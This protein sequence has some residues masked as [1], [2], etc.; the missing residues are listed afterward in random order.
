MERELSIQE[1]SEAT[2]LSSHTLRYYERAG[3]LAPITRTEGGQRRFHNRD[4]EA[5]QF[6]VKLRRTGM[7]I[8]Q[9][10]RYAEL[11]REGPSTV[12]ERKSLLEEHRQTVLEDIRHLEENL[13]VL[14]HKIG[15]YEE[16]QRLPEDLGTQGLNSDAAALV[17][18]APG[19]RTEE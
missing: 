18:A 17:A 13:K 5:L 7:P 16:M 14:E 11:L 15:L 1:A 9:I 4:V 19:V 10:R 8:R 2:G 6:L 3:L 12:A